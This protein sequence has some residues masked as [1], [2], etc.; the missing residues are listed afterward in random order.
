[1]QPADELRF[2][3]AAAGD[4][5]NLRGVYW[6]TVETQPGRRIAQRSVQPQAAPL[7]ATAQQ[8]VHW[9]EPSIYNSNY[10][11]PAGDHWFGAELRS[12]PQVPDASLTIPMPP[13]LPSIA[14]DST[15]SVSGSATRPGS[16]QLRA[17]AGSA[18][19]T[20]VGNGPGDV[21]LI[22][23]LPDNAPDLSLALLPS[24][25]FSA[26][27]LQRISWQ[28]PVAL[29]FGGRG[30]GFDGVA[31]RWRY[32][33]SGL[34][35][36]YR[37][38]D[39]S[40]AGAPVV[41]DV[42]GGPVAE[43]EDSL[44]G[45]SYVIAGPG[46]ISTPEVAAYRAAD[47]A[48][49]IN[50]DAVYIAPAA[51][52]AALAPLLAHRRSQGYAVALLD[53]QAIYD[54]W[55]FG[56]VSPAAIRRFLQHATATWSRVPRSVVLVGDGTSDP[57]NFLGR[58]NI[59]WIPPYLAMVDPWLGETACES[60]FGQ[61]DGADPL[62]DALPD[63]AVGRLPVKS[64]AELSALVDKLVGYERAPLSLF[65]AGGA[66]L[67]A[68]NYRDAVGKAD[69]GGDFAAISDAAAAQLPVGL[70]LTRI[71]YD[72][73]PGAPSQS[74]READAVRA[75]RR[76]VEALNAG[77]A[78]AMYT[79][80][81]HYWQWAS[82]DLSATQTSLLDLYDADLLQ[83][84]A[85]L[86]V[87][88]EMTCLTSAFHEPAISGT[89]IDERLL[90]RPGGGVAAVWGPTGLGVAHGHDSLARGFLRGL[91]LSPV[92]SATLGSLTQAGYLELFA[93]STCCQ[94]TLR[95][96]A[97]LGDPLT[98]PRVIPFSR[99]FAPSIASRR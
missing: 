74:W 86:P 11:G 49:P 68:D 61:L 33:L 29:E 47:L 89:T 90:L 63:I 73:S 71:Y 31:G 3:A 92:L 87:L 88:L 98:V 70:P 37:V 99:V 30:A 83:N 38:Y 20:A 48:A 36:Q 28:R 91:R 9:R 7:R 78:L 12:G 2:F 67:V 72:P 5:W 18:S 85:R 27:E 16:F 41:L 6:L 26:L 96:F 22:L 24:A 44:P 1:M 66:T 4:R 81:S 13:S 58:N 77:S 17:A 25:T 82:T 62:D 51:F 69:A 40:D 75:H 55:S 46:S 76:V 50:A 94:D 95:T 23:R 52:H 80:H 59:N 35:S 60:C 15:V 79:G 53:V 21:N 34:P 32:R 45:R 93:A 54:N 84:A 56:Y 19:A 57:H 42:A 64:A 14:G 43:F 10:A 97:I 65:A 39:I 8:T